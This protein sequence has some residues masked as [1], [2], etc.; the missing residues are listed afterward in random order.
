VATTEPASLK[1]WPVLHEDGPGFAR[2]RGVLEGVAVR[3]V[4]GR[5][6]RTAGRRGDVLG[7][8]G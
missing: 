3:W 6:E 7:A 2:T 4:T 1:V 5:V 8:E